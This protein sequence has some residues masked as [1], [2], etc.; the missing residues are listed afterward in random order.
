MILIRHLPTSFN[1]K[2]LLQGKIDNSILPI[3]EKEKKIIEKNLDFIKSTYKNPKILVSA[4]KRTQETALTY[5][6]E[7]F[8]IDTRLNEFDFGDYEGK[9]K[10]LMVYENPDWL[11]SP[12]TLR[13][14]EGMESFSTRVFNFLQSTKKE[15]LVVF[16]HGAFIRAVISISNYGCISKMNQ[17]EIKNNEL[18]HII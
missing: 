16:G 3:S 8:I 2:G 7:S 6:F 15:D 1:E 14:G 4:L 9:Q 10:S 5:G 12:L 18:I 13:F 17:I 11:T